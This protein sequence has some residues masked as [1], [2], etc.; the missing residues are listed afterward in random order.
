MAKNKE[1]CC[2]IQCCG[3]IIVYIVLVRLVIYEPFHYG[4]LCMK[5]KSE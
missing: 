2:L 1:N 3:L 5:G 4:Y